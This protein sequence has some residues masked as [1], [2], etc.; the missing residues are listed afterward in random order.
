MNFRPELPGPIPVA[1]LALLITLAAFSA[2]AMA[3]ADEITDAADSPDPQK[4][5]Q[6][7][8]AKQLDLKRYMPLSEVRTGMKGIVRTVFAGQK[9]EEFEV[10]VLG[11]LGSA[12]PAQ[13]A[14]IVR[15]LGENIERTGVAAGMSGSPM[16]IDGRMVGALAFTWLYTREPI[17]GIRPIEDM[18]LV[19]ENGASGRRRASALDRKNTHA[20]KVDDQTYSQ[21]TLADNQADD[22]LFQPGTMAMKP[23]ATPLMVSGA[24]PQALEALRS[25][26]QQRNMVLLQS[27]ATGTATGRSSTAGHQA[28]PV[29]Q[30]DAGNPAAQAQAEAPAAPHRFAPG[31][32]VGVLLMEGDLTLGATGTITDVQGDRLWAFGHGF[33]Q[34]GEFSLPITTADIITV[35]SRLDNSFKLSNMGPIVGTMQRDEAAAIYGRVGLMPANMADITVEVFDPGVDLPRHYRYRA[36]DHYSMIHELGAVAALSSLV[37]NNALPRQHTVRYSFDVTFRNHTETL[38]VAGAAAGGIAH[39]MMALD[40]RNALEPLV[41]NEYEDLQVLAIEGRIE[42]DDEDRSVSLAAARTVRAEV[43]PGQKI[44]ID[45]TLLGQDQIPLQREIEYTVPDDLP[46]GRY[47]LDICDNATHIRETLQEQPRY[48]RIR[49]T[50]DLIR[51]A[52][53]RAA[54]NAYYLRLHTEVTGLAVQGVPMPDLPPS[55]RGLIESSS[56][57]AEVQ[58]HRPARVTVQECAVLPSGRQSVIL[59]V[60]R[61]ARPEVQSAMADGSQ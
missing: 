39:I 44:A 36:T 14:I 54:P 33:D 4:Q 48:R 15:C 23:I 35:I 3:A 27:A 55:M 5:A 47:R 7:E 10:E 45:L 11:I 59:N 43:R 25:F 29:H 58:A 38:T 2:A 30:A 19:D 31:D 51:L 1:A 26:A 17:A 32:P 37:A 49:G 21:L 9:I 57:P 28:N 50:D 8:P 18:L 24:S 56:G 20:V 16:Y 34:S 6:A 52:Q 46:D 60:N 41:Q 13:S 42:V 61:A 22:G 12:G 40:L 53:L